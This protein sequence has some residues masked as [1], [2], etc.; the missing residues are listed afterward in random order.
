M[1][2]VEKHLE[3]DYRN[4]RL[5]YTDAKGRRY[6]RIKGTLRRLCD[7]VLFKLSVNQLWIRQHSGDTRDDRS[8]GN[9]CEII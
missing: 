3:Y 9:D 7:D 2:L 5:I 4:V 6:E 8:E 1:R